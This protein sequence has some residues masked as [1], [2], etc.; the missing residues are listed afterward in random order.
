MNCFVVVKITINSV[1]I[2]NWFVFLALYNFASIVHIIT[3][4]DIYLYT[5]VGPDEDSYYQDHCRFIW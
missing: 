1:D 5:L 4:G 3:Q 2:Y